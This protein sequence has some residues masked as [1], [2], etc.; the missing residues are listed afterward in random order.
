MHIE[1]AKL[2]DGVRHI[3]HY[4]GL[5]EMLDVVD[6]A[7]EKC[8]LGL[9]QRIGADPDL[10]GEWV[11]GRLN[12]Y[13]ATRDCLR[14]A[15]VPDYIASMAEKFREQLMS[16]DTYRIASEKAA[17]TKRRRVFELDGGELDID[18]YMGQQDECW[19]RVTRG[20]QRPVI[21]I[22]VNFMAQCDN[23]ESAFAGLAALGTC[24]ALLAEQAGCALE[25]MAVCFTGQYA[26][27]YVEIGSCLPIK[28]ANEPFHQD[29]LLVCGVPGYFRFYGVHRATLGKLNGNGHGRASQMTKPLREHLGLQHVL[30]V[31]WNQKHQQMFLDDFVKTLHDA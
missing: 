30:E 15:A 4:N 2:L 9:A 31:A 27:D 3:A 20:L 24:C 19:V 11:H 28:H 18:R 17:S 29:S 8:R 16:S 14:Y 6:A 1:K 7:E 25:I 13:A 23:N 26:K 21:R 10:E 22:A 5:S 12:T